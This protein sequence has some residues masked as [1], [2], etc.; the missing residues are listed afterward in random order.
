[1]AWVRLSDDFYD[2]PKFDKAGS[3]GIA[4]FAAGLAWCNRNLSDGFIPRKTALRL[5]DFDDAVE[6]VRNADRNAVTNEDDNDDLTPAIARIVAQRLVNA[7]LWH[8]AEGG[9][10]VHDYL[11]Y[12]GSK[13]QVE[14]G[15][16]S[17]A[18]RQKA[19][20]DRRNAEN[21]NA[22][23]NGPVTPAPNPN[24]NPKKKEEPLRGPSSSAA[25]PRDTDEP[26]EDIERICEHLTERIEANGSK[27]PTIT[28]GWRNAA[29]LMLDK[30][31]R[32][33]DQIHKA[34]DWCQA[35]EFWRSNILSLP[36]L[37]EKYDQLRL[38]AQRDGNRPAS[39]G[40]HKPWTSPEDESD[41]YG[42]L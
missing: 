27:R 30:D 16:Q 5:L 18:A 8:E 26:R 12:Q 33:E 22:V 24:P 32:T 1:M 36:K 25:S 13:L 40:G 28:K 11:E 14:A 38:T 19:W 29:R 37:R 3:L 21:R 17:N 20:R 31:N 6:A 9:Y 2:H 23:T 41:Y 7:G 42:D 39:G 34:I 15:R 10:Q 35:D 4:L